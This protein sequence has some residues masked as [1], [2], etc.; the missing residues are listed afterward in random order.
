MA[1]PDDE[2]QLATQ[3]VETVRFFAAGGHCPATGGNFSLRSSRG[4][5][6][7]ASGVDKS[8]LTRDQLLGINLDGQLLTSGQPSAETELHLALYRFD[9]SISAVLHIHSVAATVLSRLISAKELRISGYEMQKA[10]ADVHSHEGELALPLVDNSQ[11]MA[12]IAAQIEQQWTTAARAHAVLVRGHGIY[13]W[14]Q[15]LAAAR[16][17]LE[18]WEFLLQCEMNRCL[19]EHR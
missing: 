2:D 5:L 17:H 7:T 16:R 18:G 10:I 19:L 14:G 6:I 11:Q 9:A 1:Q 4:V 3:L 12:L 13:A 15:S 8:A